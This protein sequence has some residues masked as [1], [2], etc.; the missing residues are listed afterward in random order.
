LGSDFEVAE[1]IVAGAVVTGVPLGISKGIQA[2]V[3]DD[4]EDEDEKKKKK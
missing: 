1:A 2:I 4:E 3:P